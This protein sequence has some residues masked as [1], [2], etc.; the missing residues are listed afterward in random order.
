MCDFADRT[1]RPGRIARLRDTQPTIVEAAD[2]T[3]RTRTRLSPEAR[4]AQL[5]ATAKAM[6]VADGLQRFTIEALAREAGVTP[7]LVYNYFASRLV[8]LQALLRHEYQ[9][10]SSNLASQVSETADFE[11]MVRV[12]I[13]SNFDHHTPGNILPILQSQPDIAQATKDDQAEQLGRTAR[14]LV[15]ATAKEYGLNR[16]Q[17]ELAVSMSSGASIAAAAHAARGQV[18]RERTI[19]TVLTYVLAGMA[20]IVKTKPTE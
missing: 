7:P 2:V 16:E 11:Q 17:A 6:I 18:E 12:F 3:A 19:D 15:R 8:F 13:A 4:R 5:L 1:P 20:A 10:F 9:T 14:F